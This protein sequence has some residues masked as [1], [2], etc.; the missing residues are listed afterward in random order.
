MRRRVVNAALTE[1]SLKDISEADLAP[2]LPSP[3]AGDFSL[4]QVVVRR[5]ETLAANARRLRRADCR[6]LNRQGGLRR[7]KITR[8]ASIHAAHSVILSARCRYEPARFS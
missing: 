3:R 2:A 1:G 8:S 5:Q 6:F 7:I 4:V